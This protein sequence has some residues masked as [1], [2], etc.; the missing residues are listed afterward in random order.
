[1]NKLTILITGIIFLSFTGCSSGG[2]TELVNVDLGKYSPVVVEGRL[3]SEDANHW[4]YYLDKK[5]CLCWLAQVNGEGKASSSSPVS[6]HHLRKH[7]PFEKFLESCEKNY[8]V[9]HAKHKKSKAFTVQHNK[10]SQD[11]KKATP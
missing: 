7:L 9:Q 1:M 4:N 11:K 6:C 2:K 10:K 5:S 8:R 3:L